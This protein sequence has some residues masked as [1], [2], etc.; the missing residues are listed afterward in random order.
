MQIDVFNGDADG[1]CALIQLRLAKPEKSQLVTGV[2]RDINLL[3]EVKVQHGDKVTVLD[4]SL[5][6][7]NEALGNILE[8]G[9]RVFYVDHHQPGK[10]PQHKNLKTL[11][12]TDTNT[13][14]SLLVN[15]YLEGKHREWAVTAAFGDNLF[16]SA[17]QAAFPLSLS[18]NQLQ[19][20]KMLGIC[21]NYNS[22]GASLAD[23][24]FAPDLLFEE[25]RSYSSPFEF[26]SDNVE[27]YEKLL[28][29]YSD[30]MASAEHISPEYQTNKIAVY[31]LPDEIWS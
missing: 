24:H 15:D 10:I 23:L 3:G 7:N 27:V 28:A 30:D 18:E 6:K 20:L 2:K 9:A 26:M 4:I 13:C 22:Y 1:I 17:K 12:N 25:L 21:I 5:A 29:G 14:T 16:E 11:I 19:R 8:Q 31:L